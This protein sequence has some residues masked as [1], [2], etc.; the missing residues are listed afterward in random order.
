MKQPK[1]DVGVL[2]YPS[3]PHSFQTGSFT[4]PRVNQLLAKWFALQAPMIFLFPLI[5]NSGV[6]GVHSH[7][8]ACSVCYG[9]NQ[10]L[11]FEYQVLLPTD[12]L[13]SLREE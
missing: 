11:V 5:P 6:K 7:T 13:H 12:C 10:L 4:E 2:L 1:E 3:L 9:L 8:W